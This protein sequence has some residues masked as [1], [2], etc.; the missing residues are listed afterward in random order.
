MPI[1]TVFRFK[2]HALMMALA[3]AYPALSYATGAATLDFAAGS[4]T[5]VSAAGSQ[6]NLGKGSEVGSGDAV[7]TGDGGRAQL[8]FTDGGMV[9]LQPGSEFRIDNYRFSGKEDGE[10]KGFFSLLKGGA[11]LYH[12]PGWPHEQAVLQGHHECCDDRYSWHRVHHSLYRCKRHIG[13]N[14]RRRH[15]GMQQCRLCDRA[16]RLFGRRQR[17]VVGHPADR[18][19]AA[20]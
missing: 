7:V 20:P 18:G 13:F 15:R 14:R 3:A 5:A 4:V 17:A 11:A 12:W 16:G 10:E 9:S 19:E 8:R 6:R 1:S 2:N